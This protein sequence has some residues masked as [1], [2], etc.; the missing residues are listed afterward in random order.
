MMII[1]PVPDQ[2]MDWLDPG[3]CGPV[4]RDGDG[5]RGVGASW[6]RAPHTQ[7]D[8]HAHTR[9]HAHRKAETRQ[10]QIGETRERQRGRGADSKIGK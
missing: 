7:T 8:R 9:T 1:L 6:E 5:W 3:E 4:W 10:I 2:M